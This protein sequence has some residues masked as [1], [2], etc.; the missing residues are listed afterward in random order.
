MQAEILC[1]ERDRSRLL[2]GRAGF[3]DPDVR[4]IDLLHPD[5]EKSASAV[6]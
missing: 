1:A 6:I 4:T 2:L 5:C 3:F